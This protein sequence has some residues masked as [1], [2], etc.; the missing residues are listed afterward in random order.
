MK[1]LAALKQQ[2]AEDEVFGA[3]IRP[4]P[5]E[6]QRSLNCDDATVGT[7]EDLVDEGQPFYVDIGGYHSPE[8]VCDDCRDEY[9]STVVRVTESK[10]E[11][12]TP[13]ISAR[14][15]EWI[16]P[17]EIEPGEHMTLPIEDLSTNFFVFGDYITCPDCGEKTLWSNTINE[18]G[19]DCFFEC[20]NCHFLMDA[21]PPSEWVNDVPELETEKKTTGLTGEIDHFM[22]G[23][24]L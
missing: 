15:E 18:V 13:D 17:V 22:T 7:V 4:F 1:G 14:N 11:W 16:E 12:D 21:E 8:A 2:Y 23:N 9:R 5:V 3:K 24:E 6:C 20:S 19:P 10:Y